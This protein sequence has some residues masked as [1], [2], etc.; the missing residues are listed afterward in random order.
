MPDTEIRILLQRTDDVKASKNRMH[1]D[2]ETDDVEA[3]VRRLEGLGASRWDHQ[4]ARGFDF[5][6]C[7]IR[8]ETNSAFFKKCIRNCWRSELP[9]LKQDRRGLPSR[10][11]PGARP[12]SSTSTGGASTSARSA[13][14]MMRRG[15][16]PGVPSVPDPILSWEDAARERGHGGGRGVPGVPALSNCLSLRPVEE[17]GCNT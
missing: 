1:L 5:G 2:L 9:G 17:I 8:G 6:Y 7:A 10:R 16:V 12:G 15:S 14:R 11:A 4:T 13:A 3:E